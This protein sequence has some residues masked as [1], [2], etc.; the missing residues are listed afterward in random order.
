M[1]KNY[2]KDVITLELEK[3]MDDL[4][5]IKL[6]DPYLL[7]HYQ[8]L[9]NREI[10]WNNDIDDIF[11]D[12]Y[13]QILTWNKEDKGIPYDER[14]PIKLF[15]NSN[16][17]CVNSVFTIIDLIKLSKTPVMT[18][19][20][21]KCLS[22]GGLLLM[23]GHKGMRYVLPSCQILIHD[24]STGAMGN[25]SK[26]MDN[27]EFTKEQ[28]AKIKEYILSSTKISEE[29]YTANYRRDWWLFADEGIELGIADKIITDLDEIL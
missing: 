22:S 14:K 16:G 18:I 29:L 6:P 12:L 28:E 8:R 17:G 11:V 3:T 24:G 7:D 15:I 21:G 25:L 27:L 13:Q 1:N 26:V 4:A 10:Y 20:L 19:G 9:S 23:A 5:N 2:S